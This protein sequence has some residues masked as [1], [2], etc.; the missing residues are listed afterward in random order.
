MAARPT[1]E[2]SNYIAFAKQANKDTEGSTFYFLK[3]LDGSGF[4]TTPAVQ[5]V[6]EGGSGQD[7]GFNYKQSEKTSG[8]LIG[9]SR[10]EYTGRSLQGLLGADA[11]SAVASG[12]FNYHRQAP[13]S[14]L[15]YFTVEQRAADMLE[16]VDACKFSEVDI[17][18]TAGEPV[19]VS[20]NFAAGGTYAFRDVASALTPSRETPRPHFYS[21]RPSITVDGVASYIQMTKAKLS[22]KR[23]L[24][25]SIQTTALTMDDIV[26][27]TAD[28]DVDFTLKYVDKTMYQ[29]IVAGGGS[30]VP[31]DLATGAFDIYVPGAPDTPSLGVGAHM[32]LLNY[33]GAK[34]NRL[35]PDGKTVYLDISGQAIVSATDTVFSEVWTGGAA[36]A[37][38]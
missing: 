22:W 11:A 10:P 2:P 17:E 25:D 6:R 37:A 34:V 29:K 15:S 33:V 26:E 7:I 27:L 35:D 28:Y 5:N 14:V 12:V 24:D 18:Y 23:A 8:Q 32:P 4:D 21:N 13:T 36:S 1:N 19:K 30:V 20:A 31:F 9:Y 38:F 16:R 3:H